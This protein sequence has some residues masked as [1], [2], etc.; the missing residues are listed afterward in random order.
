MLVENNKPLSSQP[1]TSQT[2]SDPKGKATPLYAAMGPPHQSRPDGGV[3][4]PC[5]PENAQQTFG[6]LSACLCILTLPC[7]MTIITH[8]FIRAPKQQQLQ[9]DSG[10]VP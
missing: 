2:G 1:L 8:T 3:P 6:E 7:K 10:E 4:D 5:R 9:A